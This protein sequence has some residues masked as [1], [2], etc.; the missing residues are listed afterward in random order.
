ME[1]RFVDSFT[2]VLKD[3]AGHDILARL[4]P[5]QPPHQDATLPGREDMP[6]PIRRTPQELREQLR[7][8][9]Q[10]VGAL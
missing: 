8:W 10:P 4:F 7:Q 9:R 2:T 5:L 3:D 1:M 6:H